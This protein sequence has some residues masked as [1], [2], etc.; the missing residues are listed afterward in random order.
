VPNVPLLGGFAAVSGIIKLESVA[1]AIREKFA[2][3]IADGNIAAATEAFNIVRAEMEEA[4]N[5]A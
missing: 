4:L 2:G 3:K 5:H 1:L